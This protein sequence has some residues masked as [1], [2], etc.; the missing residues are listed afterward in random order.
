MMAG[1]PA[2]FPEGEGGEKL[3]GVIEMLSSKVE[4]QG[5]RAKVNVEEAELDELLC[6]LDEPVRG[7]K[8]IVVKNKGSEHSKM[9]LCATRVEVGAREGEAGVFGVE[10]GDSSKIAVGDEVEMADIESE[11]A[12]ASRDDDADIASGA[13]VSVGSAVAGHCGASGDRGNTDLETSRMDEEAEEGQES[14]NAEHVG[15]GGGGRMG[16]ESRVPE[17]MPG[18]RGNKHG[19]DAVGATDA[20]AVADAVDGAVAGTCS[21]RDA[22]YPP[23]AAAEP[24]A[25]SCNALPNKG[26]TCSG[27]SCVAEGCSVDPAGQ[28]QVQGI[29]MSNQDKSAIAAQIADEWEDFVGCTGDS[30]WEEVGG[31]SAAAAVGCGTSNGPDEPLCTCIVTGVEERV[32]PQGTKE[33]VLGLAYRGSGRKAGASCAREVVLRGSWLD[34]DVGEGDSIVVIAR[35]ELV[36]GVPVAVVGGGAGGMIV[37]QPGLLVKASVVGGGFNCQRKVVLQERYARPGGEATMMGQLVHKIFQETI[38]RRDW[39]KDA[40]IGTLLNP[41]P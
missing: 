36:H 26:V 15:Q 2:Q 41:K 16:E 28:L 37:T 6:A 14:A 31:E 33:K 27:S 38:T 19:E 10:V 12:G 39:S 8:D 5:Q 24:A 29:E 25:G 23:N 35:W 9:L 21:A 13:D 30:M 40:L 7:G 17:A 11:V 18:D 22:G 20:H 34:A 32:S 3:L 1:S 4:G